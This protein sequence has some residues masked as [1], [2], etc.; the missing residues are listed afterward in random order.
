MKLDFKISNYLFWILIALIVKGIFFWLQVCFNYQNT[1]PLFGV[2]THDSGEYYDSV[3]N[4]YLNGIYSPDVRM[5]GL[6][7]IF[8][9]LRPFF[10]K[11]VILNIILI[12]QW[13]IS[14]VACYIIALIISKAVK[15]ES[16]F[17]FIYFL[18]TFTH[19]IFLWSNFL[20]T[21][22][23]CISFFIFSL[24]Y[25]NSFQET[26]SKKHLFLSGVFF[27]WCVF[28]RPVFLLFFCFAVLF[29]ILTLIKK[30]VRFKTISLNIL[31]FFS[32]F[33]VCDSIWTIRT[34]NA[35]HKFIF[36]NDIDSYSELSTTTPIPALY[37][38]MESWGGDLENEMSWFEP[39]DKI[40]YSVKD[41]T[42]PNY[43]FTS[44][45]N[46]DSLILVKERIGYWKQHPNDSLVT[47][48]NNSLQNYTRSVKNE[49]PYLY[50]VGSGFIFLRKLI[51]SGYADF[52]ARK[53]KLN[54]LPFYKWLLKIGVLI[55]FYSIF[56]TGVLS[57]LWFLLKKKKN[58]FLILLMFI[59]FSN[60]F[61]ISFLFRTPEF[62]Y[63]LPSSLIFMC[64][65]G[66]VLDAGW[67]LV[68]RKIISAKQ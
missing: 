3:E 2:F 68:K 11:T 23:F 5:P 30:Q 61:Y 67:D 14:S 54:E 19:F 45:F 18:I 21:E 9:L 50:Y 56:F 62:R 16:V 10:E 33:I 53:I 49:K 34:Y 31:L 40:D 58:Y 47:I 36:L 28:L 41:T 39:D 55:L 15:K 59:A 57:S 51:F 29:V 8:L 42:L 13:L 1:K 32:V 43:M 24:Y 25:L 22:S 60:L 44:Q 4:F 38:F 20:L 63:V 66:I 7:I 6:G 65:C 37:F 12:L 27:T 64:F 35:K 26:D 52:N 48:L 17:Y 46:L